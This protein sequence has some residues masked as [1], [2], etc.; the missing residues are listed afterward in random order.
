M[1]IQTQLNAD[2]AIFTIPETD[3]SAQAIAF[4]LLRFYYDQQVT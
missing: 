1:Y 4:T 2:L 3:A